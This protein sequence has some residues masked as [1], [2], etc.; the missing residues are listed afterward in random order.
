MSYIKRI[1]EEDLVEKLAASGAVL[2]RGPKSCGKTATA[3][4]Y[5]KSVLEMDRDNQV[6]NYNGNKSPTFIGRKHAEIN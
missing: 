2:L 5:A 3:Q 6:P 1:I 4:Q